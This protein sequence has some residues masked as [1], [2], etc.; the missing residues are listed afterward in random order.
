MTSRFTNKCPTKSSIRHENLGNQ[1]RHKF[2][3]LQYLS[4][5]LPL[6]ILQDGS[7]WNNT[8]T[9]SF[10][11]AR[12]STW[13]IFIGLMQTLAFRKLMILRSLPSILYN[14]YSLPEDLGEGVRGV[15][16]PGPNAIPVIKT[17]LLNFSSG[18][19]FQMNKSASWSFDSRSDSI[20]G[21]SRTPSNKNEIAYFMRMGYILSPHEHVRP[22]RFFFCWN[23]GRIFGAVCFD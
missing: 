3:Q 7:M 13:R 15:Y 18:Y 22:F 2:I 20:S 4:K 11:L 10:H 12:H 8:R 14:I 19:N 23:F 17:I 21:I 9:G 6:F 1:A 16:R 5:N